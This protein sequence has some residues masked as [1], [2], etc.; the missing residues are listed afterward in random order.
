[1]IR[2][3]CKQ[4]VTLTNVEASKIRG[5]V[6]QGNMKS[7]LVDHSSSTDPSRL[8]LKDLDTAMELD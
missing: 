8:L 3:N 7:Y 5:M 2:G 6:G 1:M 4:N